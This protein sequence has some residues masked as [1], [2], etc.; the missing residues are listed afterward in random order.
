M[1]VIIPGHSY[2]LKNYK[3]DE[4]AE[5][6]LQFMQKDAAGNLTQD[7]TTNEEVLEV[8]IDRMQVLNLMLPSRETSIA[9]TKLQEAQMWLFRRTSDRIQ[10]GVEGTHKQ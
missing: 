5:Q 3:G 1:K 2:E 7:G 6:F 9:I 4:V 10:R 8:M